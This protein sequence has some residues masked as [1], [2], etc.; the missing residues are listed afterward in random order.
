MARLGSLLY[1][2][3]FVTAGLSLAL[4]EA[5]PGWNTWVGGPLVVLGVWILARGQRQ[6]PG[7]AARA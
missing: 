4:G 5:I 2:Q 6:A 7:A 1:F 3:P